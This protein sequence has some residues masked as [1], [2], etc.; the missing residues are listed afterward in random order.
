MDPALDLKWNKC[1]LTNPT[2]Y[3]III[4]LKFFFVKFT[5]NF[6]LRLG[7]TFGAKKCPKFLNFFSKFYYDFHFKSRAGSP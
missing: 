7:Q 3:E 4:K 5:P 6:L 2:V 1:H